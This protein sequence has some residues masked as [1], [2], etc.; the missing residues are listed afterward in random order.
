MLVR[1]GRLMGRGSGAGFSPFSLAIFEAFTTPPTDE[2]KAIIDTCV[3]AMV[4]A[5]VWEKL[6]VL[7]LFAAADSQ[8]ALI[9]WVAPGTYDGTLVNAP[10]FAADEGFTGNG[11]NTL[12]TTGFN[13]T[14]APSPKFTQDSASIFVRSLALGGDDFYAGYLTGSTLSL[15]PS[16]IIRM[17]AASGFSADVSTAGFHHGVRENATDVKAY[18]NGAANGT[19]TEASVAVGN[20]NTSVLGGNGLFTGAQLASYGIGSS[21]SA[22]EADALYDAELAYM[23]AVGAVA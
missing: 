19:S 15:W 5:G 8:A 21:M 3:N 9:N 11:S 13:P 7:Y 12:I 17:N 6:D 4:A 2:R 16:L 20:A 10:T 23:Q 1:P 18:R 22:V 14:T